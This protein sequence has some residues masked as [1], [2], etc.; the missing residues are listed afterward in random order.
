MGVSMPLN[1]PALTSDACYRAFLMVQLLR[2]TGEH[3]F[4]APLMALFFWIAA[5]D[6]CKQADLAAQ[7]DMSQSSISRM[8]MMTLFA[9]HGLKLIT[10]VRR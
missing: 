10:L 6:G 7:L 8:L 5:H 3:E 9:T 1:H 4:P 2:S